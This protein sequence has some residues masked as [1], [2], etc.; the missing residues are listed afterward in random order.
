MAQEIT[1]K[2]NG[3]VWGKNYKPEHIAA[4]ANVANTANPL[5]KTPTSAVKS[6]SFKNPAAVKSLLEN[7][8]PDAVIEFY[9]GE[10]KKSEYKAPMFANRF[11]VSAGLFGE[12]TGII[13]GEKNEKPATQD[14]SQYEEMG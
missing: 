1:I 11:A 8:G 4:L 10:E 2:V 13:F 6:A 7:L 5:A 12:M 3:Q 9:T 14:D